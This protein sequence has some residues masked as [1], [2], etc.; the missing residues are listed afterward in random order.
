[1]PRKENDVSKTEFRAQNP[2]IG[3]NCHS[4]KPWFDLTSR[5]THSSLDKIK[6]VTHFLV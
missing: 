3:K 6:F 5:A 2:P 4:F 1:V